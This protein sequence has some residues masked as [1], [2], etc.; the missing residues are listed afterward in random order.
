MLDA[1]HWSHSPSSLPALSISLILRH[2]HIT[3]GYITNSSSHICAFNFM[4]FL[5]IAV[6]PHHFPP[7]PPDALSLSEKLSAVQQSESARRRSP[8]RLTTASCRAW[9][10]LLAEMNNVDESAASRLPLKT[11]L[12]TL[13][14]FIA[15]NVRQPDSL[16]LLRR[17]HT[18][19]VQHFKVLRDSRGQYYLWTEKFPSLNQLVEHYKINSISR[20]NQIFLK[21]PHQ[22]VGHG[23]NK[24][25]VMRCNI[26][27]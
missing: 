24:H 25:T 11:C 19:D 21:D 23:F 12:V 16:F 13:C 10:H 15:M 26:R 20:Q 27:M 2:R 4:N 18:R 22:P 1:R 17:R 7:P 14:H 9:T 8:V 6:R 5:Y 3:V